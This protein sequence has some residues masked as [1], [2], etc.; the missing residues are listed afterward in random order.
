MAEFTELTEEALIAVEEAVA[1]AIEGDFPLLIHLCPPEDASSFPLRKVPP[2]G[3]EVIRVVEIAGHDFSPCCGTHV[4]RTGDIGALRVLG[5]EKYKGMTRISF[6]AGR[7]VL[8][9]SR[10]LRQNGDI[11]SRALKIPVAETGRGVLEFLE[12]ARETEKKLKILE[13]ESARIQ[14][15][16]LLRDAKTGGN[17][18]LIESLGSAG[19]DETLRIGRAA[20]KLSR[21]IFILLSP[22]D[23]KF[24]A[25]CSDRERDVR[26]LVKTAM[27]NHGGKGG[28]GASFFQGSFASLGEMET[29]AEDIRAAAPGKAET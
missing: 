14:A 7:R 11:I 21:T 19:I 16:A 15:E 22:R 28:G 26:F 1:D 18:V 20:Q 5:A 29:F 12:K 17:A 8:R 25:F 27:E 13:E 9:D 3:E 4:Q 2:Q 6:I 10:A 23:L 24:A